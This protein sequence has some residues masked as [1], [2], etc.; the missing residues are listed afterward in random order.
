MGGRAIHADRSDES[1]ELQRAIVCHMQ[2]SL[3]G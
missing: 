1:I 2:L 3:G